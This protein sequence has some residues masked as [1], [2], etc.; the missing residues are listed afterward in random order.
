MP[1]AHAAQH[2]IETALAAARGNVAR[3]AR[4]LGVHR[5]TVYRYLRR[6]GGPDEHGDEHADEHAAP[7]AAKADLHETEATAEQRP[8]RLAA[9][10]A[11]RPELARRDLAASP[12][13]SAA[14]DRKRRD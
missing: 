7:N 11:D 1:L 8:Q 10:S 14:P 13:T 4:V 6:G 2:A 5:S 3:A 9:T 12:S